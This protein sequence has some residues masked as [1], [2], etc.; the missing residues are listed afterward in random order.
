[1]A[2]KTTPR[3]RA[4][5]RR[6]A[7]EQRASSWNTGLSSALRPSKKWRRGITTAL[8]PPQKMRLSEWADAKFVLSAESAAE[9]GRWRT[10]SYQRGIMD[11]ITHPDVERVSVMKS[12]RIGYTKMVD[13]TIGY[14]IEQDP[15]PIMVVQPTVEDAEGYSKEEIAPMVRDVAVLS[16]LVG[17][18]SPRR[19]RPKK[20][21]KAKESSSKTSAETILLKSFPGGVLSMVGA[22]SGRGFRRVSRRI[23]I[24][25]EVDGYPAS[26][27]NEG[28]PVKLGERRAEYYWNRKIIAGSTPLIAGTSRIEELYNAGD[29]RRY[30]VPC[31]HC[32]HMDYLRFSPEYGEGDAGH[33][34]TWGD[35]PAKAHFV[36][37]KCKKTIEESSKRAMID[38]GEWRAAGEFSGHASFHIWTAYSLSPNAT[39]AQIAKEFLDAKNDP[40][41]LKTFVNT[42][43]GETWQERGDA[44]EW[45]RLYNRR[46]TYK[47]CSVPDATVVITAGV[48]VQ[49]DRFYYEV[50]AWGE[51]K[52]SWSI[53]AGEIHGDTA[54]EATWQKLDDE[55][56]SAAYFGA[57]GGAYTIS[58][59]AVD[60]GYNTQM[61]YAW[62]RGKPRVMT[63]KGASGARAQLLG[64]PSRVDVTVSGKKIAR[65]HKLWPVGGDI[66]KSELYGWLRL[67]AGEGGTPSGFCHFPEYGEWYFKQLTSEHLVTTQNRKTRQVKRE[68]HVLPNR[69]NHILDCRV[70]AR[71]AAARLGIDRM[72]ARA[73]AAAK[74]RK[75]P[76]TAALAPAAPAPQQPTSPPQKPA[77][78]PPKPGYFAGEWRAAGGWFKPR[79]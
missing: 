50:V 60:S 31:P 42:V 59:L 71:A 34:M 15:C 57:D 47:I 29:R 2:K 75:K 32:D 43:L 46:E 22:N 73:R 36:C 38:A 58:Q 21:S 7:P 27:G 14:Y 40:L 55:L 19:G 69:E 77:K 41:K 28:D 66:A 52:E 12:A 5:A 62:A 1:M 70:Y 24:F 44:P 74:K 76:P 10:L 23:V 6:A 48:D 49:K 25:D 67:D 4:R 33:I 35:D 61:A 65:G 53:D 13:A 64:T 68:W 37:S 3:S 26:A 17:A 39:W 78:K 18:A 30:Y 51:N 8:R 79:R 11:A 20:G 72:T 63:I 16:A 56:L 45:E 9:P 54:L